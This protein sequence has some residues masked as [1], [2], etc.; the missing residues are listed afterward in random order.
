[1][2]LASS[3]EGDRVLDCFMG[4]G[5]TAIACQQFNRKFIGIEISKEYCDI[6]KKR[7]SQQTLSSLKGNKSNV[8]GGDGN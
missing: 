6:A 3:N 8:G 4:S 5:T 2:I 7:L 1:M